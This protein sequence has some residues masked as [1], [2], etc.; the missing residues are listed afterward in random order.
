MRCRSSTIVLTSRAHHHRVTREPV[1]QAAPRD[2]FE[3]LLSASDD[4]LSGEGLPLVSCRTMSDRLRPRHHAQI[5][6]AHS[7]SFAKNRFDFPKEQMEL[8]TFNQFPRRGG[9]RT[10]AS[11]VHFKVG[12]SPCPARQ[13]PALAGQGARA[14]ARRHAAHRQAPA[15]PTG[16]YK[17]QPSTTCRIGIPAT[18]WKASA[19]SARTSSAT[20]GTSERSDALDSAPDCAR[21]SAKLGLP[22]GAREAEPGRIAALM[23]RPPESP[24]QARAATL[25]AMVNYINAAL[26]QAHRDDRRPDRVRFTKIASAA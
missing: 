9:E 21:F 20:R 16:R 2:R 23:S 17:R 14:A 13:R 11:D 1:A 5:A 18:R 3:A 26:P 24:A 12:S 15:S 10:G 8:A 4:K 7:S 22:Q 25:A 19:G 6:K